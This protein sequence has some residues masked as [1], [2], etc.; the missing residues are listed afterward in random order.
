MSGANGTGGSGSGSSLTFAK[1][2][3]V[4]QPRPEQLATKR[5]SALGRLLATSRPAGSQQ[6]QGRERHG[7]T[8]GPNALYDGADVAE[9]DEENDGAPHSPL[10]NDESGLTAERRSE[11]STHRATHPELPFSCRVFFPSA[12][13]SG[14]A[15]SGGSVQVHISESCTVERFKESI[16]QACLQAG[17]NSSSSSSSSSSSAVEGSSGNN[18]P[19]GPLPTSSSIRLWCA[20]L[21]LLAATEYGAVDEDC[22]P[23]DPQLR[24]HQFGVQQ[25]VL[26]PRHPDAVAAA[27][28]AAAANA[29]AASAAAMP[30]AA[31]PPSSSNW[32]CGTCA[33]YGAL[34]LPASSYAV[35]IGTKVKG[36]ALDVSS[37]LCHACEAGQLDIVRRLIE[38][39]HA[40]VNAT[41]IDNWRP[42][43]FAARKGHLAVSTYLLKC[44][45]AVDAVTKSKW[46]PLLLACYQGHYEVAE[47]L[48][49]CG[50]E[51]SPRDQAGKTPLYYAKQ[52]NDAR[53]IELLID[54][55]AGE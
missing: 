17:A 53:M 2:E 11:T 23:L 19:R 50:A 51:P 49:T 30:A 40:D 29:A 22:P 33:S 48:L 6:Q 35:N 34:R 26:L 54:F 36:H 4:T 31:P 32:Q 37:R 13:N 1:E 28:A 42:L 24:V 38:L 45:A 25:F 39:Q 3:V 44:D 43:H 10:A 8:G 7:H 14:S 15:A 5:T 27:A 18:S 41:S 47:I 52:R 12:S 46:T 55:Q 9:G 20:H 16:V 21:E